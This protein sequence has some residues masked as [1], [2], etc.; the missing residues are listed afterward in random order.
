[1]A[2]GTTL[3]PVAF[4]IPLTAG[5]GDSPRGSHGAV[6][7]RFAFQTVGQG[8]RLWQ[9]Y[10]Q[11]VLPDEPQPLPPDAQLL[12]RFRNSGPPPRQPFWIWPQLKL[13]GEP[14]VPIAPVD[15]QGLFRFRSAAA[16]AINGQPF[17]I[18]PRFIGTADIEPLPVQPDNT[19]LHR[20]RTTYQT[21]GQPVWLIAR[22]PPS[23]PEPEQI[24]VQPDNTGLFKVRN[25]QRTTSAQPFWIFPRFVGVAEPEIPPVLANHSL[26]FR[27]RNPKIVA[28]PRQP[29]WWMAMRFIPA[30]EPEPFPHWVDQQIFFGMRPAPPV[31][32]SIR[33]QAI[34]DGEYGGQF[35][36]AGD[37]FDILVTAF[38]NN[39]VNYGPNSATIQLG[40]MVQVPSSTPLY[41]ARTSGIT[42]IG[43]WLPPNDG[44]R[45]TVF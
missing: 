8:Y 22:T 42:S 5:C 10:A 26:L 41:Q 2:G 39:A 9:K 16:P 11:P 38:S 43:T 13:L 24:I 23:I 30:P 19:L 20:Y 27:F 31:V 34:Y 35:Y 7:Y 45:R 1:M 17:W 29:Y 40:W 25:P 6:P 12:F 36:E 15:S 3:F 32:P 14:E 28:S 21:V 33:V 18:W 44:G 4:Y 37:V